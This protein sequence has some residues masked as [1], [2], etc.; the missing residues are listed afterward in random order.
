LNG[1]SDPVVTTL[2]NLEDIDEVDQDQ[3]I[4]KEGKKFNFPSKKKKT[5]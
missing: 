4:L 1:V 3:E 2:A 5:L